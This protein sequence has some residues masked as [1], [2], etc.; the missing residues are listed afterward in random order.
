LNAD[1][2]D[3]EFRWTNERFSGIAATRPLVQVA[4]VHSNWLLELLSAWLVGAWTWNLQQQCIGADCAKSRA[5]TGDGS[6]AFGGP[7][8]ERLPRYL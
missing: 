3:V 8:V 2:V 6:Q 1:V 4:A 5:E 7:C